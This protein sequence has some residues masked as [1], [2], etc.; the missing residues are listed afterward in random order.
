MARNIKSGPRKMKGEKGL[1]RSSVKKGRP[2]YLQETC[3]PYI[4]NAKIKFFKQTSEDDYFTV[5][6]LC[7]ELLHGGDDTYIFSFRNKAGLLDYVEVCKNFRIPVKHSKLS[8]NNMIT[9]VDVQDTSISIK[10]EKFHYTLY[11][12]R[13][14]INTVFKL[15]DQWEIL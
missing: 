2:I 6:I 15:I 10:V 14:F 9:D 1:G 12:D 5:V 8:V 3:T 4:L 11:V 13:R 7:N